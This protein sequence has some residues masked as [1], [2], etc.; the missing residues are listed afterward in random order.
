MTDDTDDTGKIISFLIGM[1][2]F[3]Y[4]GACH[5]SPTPYTTTDPWGGEIY[6]D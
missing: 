5:A 6:A 1:A 2:L 3:I 4:I